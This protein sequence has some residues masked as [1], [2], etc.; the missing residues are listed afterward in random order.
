MFMPCHV[1]SDRYPPV[2]RTETG[3]YVLQVEIVDGIGKWQLDLNRV[4][5][6]AYTKKLPVMR[7]QTMSV[8]SSEPAYLYRTCDVELALTADE[9]LRLMRH[10]LFPKEVLKLHKLYGAFHETH[11]DFYDE[12][13]GTA[14]QPMED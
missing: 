8:L 12:E 9:M 5:M 14:L 10:D 13:T 1:Y 11:D 3:L 6:M 7:P 2:N 4:A